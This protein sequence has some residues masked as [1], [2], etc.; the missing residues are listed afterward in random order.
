MKR[1]FFLSYFLVCSF[2]FAQNHW[3]YE[4][5]EAPKYWGDMPENIK[6]NEKG[7]QSP[8]DIV[9]SQVRN[10]T[11]LPDIKFHY[12][13]ADVNNIE[14]NG[15]SLQFNF[16]KRRYIQYYGKKYELIQ[17]HAHEE[18]EHTVN[19]FRYPLEMHFVHKAID[20]EI[21]VVAVFFKVGIE[22]SYFEKLNVFKTI[23]RN[24][25]ASTNIRF[26]PEKI[27]PENKVYYTYLGS[28]T[29][30]PCSDHVRWIV[31]K[32]P[33]EMTEDE[34]KSISKHLPKN[35]NRPVQPLMNRI[36]RGNT[37]F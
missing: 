7:N 11:S 26:N 1:L 14:D 12:N 6:C 17:F 18:S 25:K 19:G 29:T 36:V 35:N 20:G 24:G 8:I 10:D 22:N 13:H 23:A 21:L 15:H 4:G 37:N 2:I 30:P 5:I 34:I 31:F 33:V 9:I 32:N 16:R 3:G 28:L 27:Y